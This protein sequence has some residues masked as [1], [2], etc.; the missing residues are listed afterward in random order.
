MARANSHLLPVVPFF[1]LLLLST[2]P[3][4][5]E[6]GK[7]FHL[8]QVGFLVASHVRLSW[9]TQ[10]SVSQKPVRRCESRLL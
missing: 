7:I 8:A 5:F 9:I 6:I 2:L 4:R 1:L 10:P 3:I